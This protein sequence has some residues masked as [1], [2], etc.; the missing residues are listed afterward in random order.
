MVELQAREY[1]VHLDVRIHALWSQ[2]LRTRKTLFSMRSTSATEIFY[3]V[4]TVRTI[5]NGIVRGTT[6]KSLRIRLEKE[7]IRLHDAS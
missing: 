1:R 6:T 4:N 2:Q 3:Q 7:G 5:P